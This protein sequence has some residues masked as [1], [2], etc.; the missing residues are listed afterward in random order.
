[1]IKELTQRYQ[2]HLGIGKKGDKI[3]E[4]LRTDRFKVKSNDS[5]RIYNVGPSEQWYKIN[6]DYVLVD[7]RYKILDIVR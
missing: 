5:P 3:P 4:P 7:H 2:D 6:S 1:M